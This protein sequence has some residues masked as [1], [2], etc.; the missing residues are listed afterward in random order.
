VK[1]DAD[2]VTASSVS[3]PW[4]GR[5][6]R[7]PGGWPFVS[8]W[9]ALTVSVFGD[10]VTRIALPTIAILGLGVGPFEAGLLSAASWIAWPVLGPF[11]GV[12]VDRLARRPVLVA[13]DLIRLALLLSI[14]AAVFLT[15]SVTF[16]QLLAVAA[17]HG[18]ASVFADLAF[19]AHVPEVVEPVDIPVANARIEASR[20]TSYV[21]G[22]TLAG[23]LIGWIGAP[24]AIVVD[25]ASFLASALLIRSAR[26]LV[27]PP[28][29]EVGVERGADVARSYRRELLDG[30]RVLRANP[31]LLRLILAAATSNFGLVAARAI[32]L[33]H[34]YRDLGFSPAV[35][36]LVFGAPGIGALVGVGLANRIGRRLGIGRALLAATVLESAVWLVIPFASGPLAGIVIG[37]ALAASSVW[38]LVW[39]V[40][41]Q[42]VRQ[43]AVGPELQGRLASI[44]GAIGFGVIPLG[45]VAGGAIAA[46]LTSTGLP[47][48]PLT[49]MIGAIVGTSSGLA[50]VGRGMTPLW[51]WR[52]GDPWPGQPS[53]T[54]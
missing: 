7:I 23:A 35:A 22:P 46:A 15:G 20:S 25:A 34:L 3:S 50:L 9:S 12:W 41:A 8:L 52:F 13:C 1:A 49:M 54:R 37:L 44:R 28:R 29:V 47:A 5:V 6:L 43:V 45:G 21:A 27:R 39:N 17:F 2:L 38:G 31:V 30:L 42:S 19:T 53:S 16:G 24:L 40:L 10:A 51:R 11:A 32:L 18:L 48:L 26:P 33:L 14:P 4:L 36:G